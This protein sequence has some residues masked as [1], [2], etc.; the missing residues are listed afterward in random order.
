MHRLS[1]YPAA[2][3]REVWS[4]T[5]PLILTMMSGCIMF[6]VDRLLLARFSL[7]A[8][9]AAASAGMAVA[10]FH[11]GFISIINVGEVFVGQ[12]NGA[13]SY[14]KVPV[15]VWQM[16]W[17]SLAS[18]LVFVPL[19]IWGKHY[20]MA[21]P[22]D[23]YGEPY[24]FWLMILG[25]IW[26]LQ[27]AFSSFFIGIAR[28]KYVTIA[29]IFGNVLNIL[30]DFILIF[31][32]EGWVPSMGSAGAAIGTVAA[33]SLQTLILIV[34]FLSKKYRDIYN[35]HKPTFNWTVLKDVLRISV[36]PGMGH[37]LEISC[38]AMQLNLLATVSQVH[39]AVQAI[40]QNVFILFIFLFDGMSKG[41]TALSSNYIG[42]NLRHHIPT[43]LFSCLKIHLV[44]IALLGVL[45]LGFPEQFIE[46]FIDPNVGKMEHDQILSFGR[47]AMFW[48]WCFVIF[49]GYAWVIAGVLTSGGDT[50]FI[51]FIGSGVAWTLGI[52][53][54]Y[55]FIVKGNGSPS[56]AWMIVALYSMVTFT[57]YLLR[58]NSKRWLKLDLSSAS[59][60]L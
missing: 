46:S 57:F 49:D 10:V 40:G 30:L 50:R 59:N 35:T 55:I 54:M 43:I 41:A 7:E 19:A 22:Y 56:D 5:F 16:V 18:A 42:A 53:P 27:A 24:F 48:I 8:M 21:D 32:V 12:Y 25:F 39:I 13:R 15:P 33:M 37:M 38:W 20:L 9:T 3:V 34:L 26:P 23:K 6:F 36:L 51:T 2:S 31:G 17:F 14:H 28:A 45:L 58:Y 47:M 60:P 52:L 1:K 4:V 29:S 44:F 11:Y